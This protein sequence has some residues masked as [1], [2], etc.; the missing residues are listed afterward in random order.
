MISEHILVID[1]NTKVIN[2]IK[3]AFP[4]YDV[5]AY[6]DGKKALSLLQKPNDVRLVLLDIMM[7][8]VDGITVLREIK[9]INPDIAVIIMTA[10]ATK[11]FAID[12]LRFHA[13]DF[14]EK[15]FNLDELRGKIRALLKER[16]HF[17]K[18]FNS[19]MI[20]RIRNFVSRNYNNIS[21]EIL[22]QYLCLAPK[23]VSRMFKEN[24]G[25]SFHD[26]VIRT[27]I[28]KA[29]EMLAKTAI[30]VEEISYKLG[31]ANPESFMRI[32]K[33]HTKT[34]PSQYRRQQNS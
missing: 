3:L 25:G 22:A 30:T 28:E 24:S 34:T 7:P 32:F 21:L 19:A 13:D 33:K 10:Y 12:A 5:S 18:S 4:E 27:K 15:P 17:G 6:S 9:N 14:I 11:D 1:D 23:Y 16:E 29:K 8:E 26:L 31:Y 20:E 2:S